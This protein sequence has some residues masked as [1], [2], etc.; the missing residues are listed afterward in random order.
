MKRKKARKGGHPTQPSGEPPHPAVPRQPYFPTSV[1]LMQ[2]CGTL[3]PDSSLGASSTVNL[4]ECHYQ[5]GVSYETRST[6]EQSMATRQRLYPDL[7]HLTRFKEG[8]RHV[9]T[10]HNLNVRAVGSLSITIT[11]ISYST[12]GS[13]QA[14]VV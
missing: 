14:W 8:P 4:P 5:E 6:D 11:V 2:S 12:C 9:T 13:P 10:V 3:L 1:L 7:A